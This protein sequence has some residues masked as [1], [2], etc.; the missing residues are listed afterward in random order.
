MCHPGAADASVINV[1]A[2]TTATFVSRMGIGV[3]PANARWCMFTHAQAHELGVRS[4]A[5]CQNAQFVPYVLVYR[6]D[7]NLQ[8]DAHD[9]LF[10][11]LKHREGSLACEYRVLYGAHGMCVCVWSNE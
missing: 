5:G 2:K 3:V 9:R 1:A 7:E 11:Q 8:F 4:S 6:P 10:N